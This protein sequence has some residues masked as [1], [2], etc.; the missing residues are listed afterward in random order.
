M[1]VIL[2]Y[3]IPTVLVGMT[4]VARLLFSVPHFPVRFGSI[5]ILVSV[6]RCRFSV[7]NRIIPI[8]LRPHQW[9][10]WT[11]QLVF[12]VWA[13]N[14]ADSFYSVCFLLFFLFILSTNLEFAIFI[15]L[16]NSKLNALHTIFLQSLCGSCT[17]FGIVFRF[18]RS[19]CTNY[20]ALVKICS[21]HWILALTISPNKFSIQVSE[22]IF[23]LIFF[24]FIRVFFFFARLN[25]FV[26]SCCCFCCRFFVAYVSDSN[27][28]RKICAIL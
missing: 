12:Y 3:R 28:I 20:M 24:S 22:R 23:L 8:N 4:S 18:S 21:F 15:V 7:S 11:D 14:L 13:K 19:I 5:V 26:I 2:V 16:F 1:S 6:W 9:S 17:R 10:M 25:S 27:A